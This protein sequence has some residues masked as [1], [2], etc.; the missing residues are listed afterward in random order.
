LTSHRRYQYAAA[1]GAVI[2]AALGVACFHQHLW[3]P[4]LVVGV[5]SGVLF[6]ASARERRNHLR[7]VT[8]HEW[9]RRAAVGD[10][11]EPLRPCCLLAGASRG[12]AH[13]HN[14]C[15]RSPI[16]A[17]LLAAQADHPNTTSKES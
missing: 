17:L 1:V 16:A 10:N 2:L 15:T 7:T 5:G 9:A 6:E 13:H 8:E 4:A 3:L 14:R 11:P 12:R